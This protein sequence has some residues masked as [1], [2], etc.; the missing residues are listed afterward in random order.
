MHME[1]GLYAIRRIAHLLFVAS[2]LR[3][4]HG[5]NPLRLPL[6]EVQECTVE[7][8]CTFAEGLLDG[9][10]T[11]M[12]SFSSAILRCR[13]AHGR[14]AGAIIPLRDPHA[15][16]SE[17]LTRFMES[18]STLEGGPDQYVSRVQSLILA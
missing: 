12:S 6:R 5:V 14:W 18:G 2:H 16:T 8:C 13:C 9:Y 15:V 17:L 1:E 7:I 3:V 4:V 11:D 10:R